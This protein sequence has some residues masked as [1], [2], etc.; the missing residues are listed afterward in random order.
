MGADVDIDDI[1]AGWSEYVYVWVRP[2]NGQTWTQF[3]RSSFGQYNEL[4]WRPAKV[5]G[6]ADQG[7]RQS[8]NTGGDSRRVSLIGENGGYDV[9]RFEFGDLIHGPDHVVAAK[10]EVAPIRKFSV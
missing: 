6:F 2:A 5:S 1:E 8:Y 3:H 7:D 9:R 10:Q 4:D